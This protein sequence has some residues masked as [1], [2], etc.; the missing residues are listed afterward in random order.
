MRRKVKVDASPVPGMSRDHFCFWFASQAVHLS[1]SLQ[2]M[3]VSPAIVA[4]LSS[5]HGAL[6]VSPDFRSTR[7]DLYTSV[8]SPQA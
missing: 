4:E 6:E 5:P 8:L 7:V 3:A 2:E 1:P